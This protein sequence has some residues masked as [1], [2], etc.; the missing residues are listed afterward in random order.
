MPAHPD[1][2]VWFIKQLKH[3]K[4]RWAGKP[5]EL[6]PFQE[7]FVRDLFALDT[8]GRR[9]IKKALLGIA[10][11]NGKSELGAALAL[12][13]LILDREPG[14]EVIGAAGKRDQA[15]LILETAKRMVR[16]SSVGGR[17]LSE[18]LVVRRDGIYF[19]EMDSRYIV[20]SADGE[21]EHGL[22]PHAVVFDE[23]HVQGAKRDLWD[24]LVTAQ[25]ARED[26][27]LVSLTTA[28]PIPAGLCYGEYQYGQ[29]I[30]RGI[31][32][33]PEYLMRWWEADRE[34][35]VD[36]PK[37]WQ[38]A[39]PGRG[40]MV[41]DSFLQSAA[42]DVLSGRAPEYTFRRLHLNQWTTALE[43]WLPRQAWDRCGGHPDIPDGATVYLAMDAALRRDSYGIAVVYVEPGFAE[44][45]NGLT[46]PADIAHCK[47][48]AFVPEV[49]GEYIDQEDVRTYVLGLAQ[50]YRV[51]E[52][53][54]DPAYMQLMAQ[55]L[56]DAGLPMQA[57]P[58][59][60]ENMSVATETFQRLVLDGRLRHGHER[61]LSEQL[62][63]VGVRETDRAVRLSKGKSGGRIDAI[64]ALVMAL[65]SALGGESNEDFAIVV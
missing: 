6:I 25:G 35:A 3:T 30:I 17:Q 63:A 4:G 19:P 46:V 23:L 58:Q 18:F 16:Y 54:Y 14:G 13:F 12:V 48:R 64:V 37:A 51:Q 10:R 45:E 32:Q 50:R 34:L 62:A 41:F 52:V 27:V 1:E 61:V 20:V 26:P 59:S 22:N 31:R 28:G 42:N 39:N 60:P 15:R 11:K 65:Q 9:R 49:D 55:Q 29:E 43:R 5:F 44:R 47:V 24:A 2:A 56:Q 57:Y 40:Y 38:Q 21:R 33:D 36:D 53:L 8:H 7:Q